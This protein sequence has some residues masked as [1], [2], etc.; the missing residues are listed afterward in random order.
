MLGGLVPRPSWGQGPGTEN[1]RW[2]W[3]EV[4]SGNIY[5]MDGHP[6]SDPTR[7]S[8]AAMRRVPRWQKALVPVSGRWKVVPA[9]WAPTGLDAIGV[10]A[11]RVAC[12]VH[13]SQAPRPE[14]GLHGQGS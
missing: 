1:A 7:V 4:T 9:P 6:S 5:I 10:T 3:S 11:F 8:T 13:L 2:A 12:S 14:R